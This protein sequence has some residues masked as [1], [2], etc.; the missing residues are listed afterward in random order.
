MNITD[1][2][3]KSTRKSP[4]KALV[5]C[6]LAA[7]PAAFLFFETAWAQVVTEHEYVDLVME[8]EYD[9]GKVIYKVQNAGTATATGVTVSFLLEDLEA[10]IDA[11]SV[12]DHRTVDS[13]NQRLTWNIGT[14]LPGE[15][16]FNQLAFSTR[17]HSGHTTWDRIES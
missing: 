12:T 4:W 16:T 14:I 2:W 10:S 9:E 7:P 3:H 13:T 6:L 17:N 8:Y 11:V 1:A 5:L 15:T